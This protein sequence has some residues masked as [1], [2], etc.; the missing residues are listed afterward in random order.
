M[1]V[2]TT[3]YVVVEFD[4]LDKDLEINKLKGAALLNYLRRYFDL[5]LVTDSGNKSVHGWFRNDAR[6]TEEAKF[7]L[8]QLGADMQTMRPSQPVRLP[9]AVQREQ[10][11]SECF[12]CPG[13]ANHINHSLL[14]KTGVWTKDSI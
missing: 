9:G 2:L 8:R 13:L 6:M 1:T 14:R 3:P 12:V 11:S 5:R 10:K 4:S 7:F